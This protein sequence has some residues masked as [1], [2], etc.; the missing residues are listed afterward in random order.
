MFIYEKY[1]ATHV[2]YLESHSL[3]IFIVG[4]IIGVI[5]VI[6]MLYNIKHIIPDVERE[7]SRELPEGW[8]GNLAKLIMKNA[9]KVEIDKKSYEYYVWKHNGY[10]AVLYVSWQDFYDGLEVYDMPILMSAEI[11]IYKLSF[12]YKK[13]IFC[14]FV[15]KNDYLLAHKNYFDYSYNYD[16]RKNM[17]I[18]IRIKGKDVEVN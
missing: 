2:A 4:A 15:D 9:Q 8:F 16:I 12:F 18:T 17:P 6:G 7:H 13:E 3:E 14:A 1:S 10:E 11:E 5:F